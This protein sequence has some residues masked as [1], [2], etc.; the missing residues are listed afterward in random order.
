MP[1]GQQNFFGDSRAVHE[2]LKLA[3]ST[4]VKKLAELA[5]LRP[6]WVKKFRQGQI[7]KPGF[8]QIEKIY[9]AFG[10]TIKA[11]KQHD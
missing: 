9:V 10:Y 1:Q 7:K 11:F 2:A 4:P 8:Q 6:G 3:Q 5:G